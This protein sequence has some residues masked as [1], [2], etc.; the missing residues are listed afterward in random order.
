MVYHWH[1]PRETVCA[2]H[3][4]V[5][6][7]TTRQFVAYELCVDCLTK[8]LLRLPLPCQTH[9]PQSSLAQLLALFLQIIVANIPFKSLHKTKSIATSTW[10]VE[11]GHFNSPVPGSRIVHR[12][13]I[14]TCWR[15]LWNQASCTC[16]R[17]SSKFSA[18][19]NRAYSGADV[20]RLH[21]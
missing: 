15:T 3:T 18:C 17:G 19:C 13:F 14:L 10:K 12:K 8:W 21:N 20:W 1:T 7:V 4:H 16:C 11:Q 5:D 9:H 6:L 2:I